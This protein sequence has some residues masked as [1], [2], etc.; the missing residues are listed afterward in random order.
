[1]FAKNR[2]EANHNKMAAL[3]FI[4]KEKKIK[5]PSVNNQ[6]QAKTM[7]QCRG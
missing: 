7:W 5:N 4:L 3:R 6:F 2:F 1:M